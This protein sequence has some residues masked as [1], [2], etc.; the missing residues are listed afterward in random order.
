MLYFSFVNAMFS[1]MVS[2]LMASNC[3]ITLGKSEYLHFE[4]SLVNYAPYFLPSVS[5]FP[6]GHVSKDLISPQ[7]TS[8]GGRLGLIPALLRSCFHTPDKILNGFKSQC[9]LGQVRYSSVLET[10]SS[11]MCLIFSP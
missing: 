2:S 5:G 7:H 9:Y 3:N 11:S 4:E 8:K 10:V 6:D 1:H